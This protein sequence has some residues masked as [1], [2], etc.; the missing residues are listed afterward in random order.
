MHTVVETNQFQKRSKALRIT[1]NEVTEII[2]TLAKNPNSGH[3]LGGGLHKVRIANQGGGKSGGYRV[4][5]FYKPQNMPLFLL[6]I[7]A[8]SEKDNIS[9]AEKNVLIELC[10]NLTQTYRSQS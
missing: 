6:T 10:N 9:Q 2:T 7:F 3:S 5:Y 1:P 8:K 4:L